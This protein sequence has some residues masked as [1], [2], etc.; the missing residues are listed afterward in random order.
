M[1]KMGFFSALPKGTMALCLLVAAQVAFSD[2][3]WAEPQL[4]RSH[5]CAS[6][7]EAQG[8]DASIQMGFTITTQGTVA[9]LVVL[10]SSGY[11][12]LDQDATDCVRGWI[13]RPAMVEGNPVAAPWLATVRYGNPLPESAA[14]EQIYSDIQTCV[15]ASGVLQRLPAGPSA[16]TELQL[17]STSPKTM[18]MHHFRPSRSVALDNKVIECARASP[19]LAGVQ[20][21]LNGRTKVL[22][23][24][25]VI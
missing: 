12:D 16:V 1:R 15:K 4:G 3:A 6:P 19:A 20:A 10:N 14:I 23:I 17:V 21:E 5:Q 9:D 8:R 13:Y 22:S 11:S 25:W 7:A 2:G 18:D 24:R